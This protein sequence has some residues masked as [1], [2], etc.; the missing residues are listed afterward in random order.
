MDLSSGFFLE[1]TLSSIN[2]QVNKFLTF[3]FIL[4]LSEILFKFYFIFQFE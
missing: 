4:F 3:I 2:H 1:G